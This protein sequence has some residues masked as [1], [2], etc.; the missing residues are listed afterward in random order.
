MF[1]SLSIASPCPIFQVKKHGKP[2]WHRLV[3]AVK[4]IN[5]ALAQT[6]AKDH[7]GVSGNHTLYSGTKLHV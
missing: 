3:K 4:K 2:T 5:R 7:P 1:N 6:I